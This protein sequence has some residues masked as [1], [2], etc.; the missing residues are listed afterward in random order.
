MLFAERADVG[1]ARGHDA[2]EGGDHLLK[3][4]VANRQ[5]FQFSGMELS[6]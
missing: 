4:F 5:K 2:I 3:A 1:F 6:P